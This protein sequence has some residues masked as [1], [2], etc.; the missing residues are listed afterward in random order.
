[1]KH[2]SLWNRH[3]EDEFDDEMMMLASALLGEVDTSSSKMSI[4][5]KNLLHLRFCRIL[6]QFDAEKALETP[7]TKMTAAEQVAM[8]TAA[9]KAAGRA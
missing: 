7:Q 9:G 6:K 3:V 5:E 1:M 8:V 4:T 2:F